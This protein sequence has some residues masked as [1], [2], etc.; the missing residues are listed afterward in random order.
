MEQ[1]YAEY[2]VK[3]KTTGKDIALKIMMIFGVVLLFLVGFLTKFQLLFLVAAV[4]VFAMV[5]FWPRFHVIWE[6]VYCDGQLDFDM[7]QGED[8]RKTVLRIELEN[9]DVIAPM[10]SERM[11]GYRH[12]RT[13]KFYSLQPDAKTYGIAVRVEGKEE[14][15]LL[16]FEPNQK[17]LDLIYTKFPKKTEISK[18]EEQ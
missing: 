14:K 18:N 10:D 7:I 13:K 16:E 5:W 4:A 8:K 12:L 3:Q 17:M 15:I 1:A 9:A 2:S 11:A 6:Y